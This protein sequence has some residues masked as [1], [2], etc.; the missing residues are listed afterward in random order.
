MVF[1]AMVKTLASKIEPFRDKLL[2]SIFSPR[3][4]EGDDAILYKTVSLIVFIVYA[5]NFASVF[6]PFLDKLL[7]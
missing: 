7:K 1:V 6:K 3:L 4:F 5:E 2:M